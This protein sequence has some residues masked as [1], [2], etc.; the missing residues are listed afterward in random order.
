MALAD[1]RDI[2]RVNMV[3]DTLANRH[4]FAFD[5]FV[6]YSFCDFIWATVGFAGRD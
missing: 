6:F 5:F 1:L 2:M 4:A 3:G